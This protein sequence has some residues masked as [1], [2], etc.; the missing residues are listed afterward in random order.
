[1]KS[2]QLPH[3]EGHRLFSQYAASS[4]VNVKVEDKSFMEGNTNRLSFR[5]P[6]ENDGRQ[7]SRMGRRHSMFSG[8]LDRAEKVNDW[9]M[10]HMQHEYENYQLLN[11][12]PSQQYEGNRQYDSNDPFVPF[13]V[14]ESRIVDHRVRFQEDM[15]MKRRKSC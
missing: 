1:M 14:N 15:G 6:I 10:R 11:G 5:G 13:E 8:G 7:H 4:R 12:N 2:D 9:A 3:H